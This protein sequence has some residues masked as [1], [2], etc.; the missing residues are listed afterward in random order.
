MQIR[1]TVKTQAP[2]GAAFDYLSDFTSTNDWD[3]GTVKTTLRHGDGGVGTTY[4]NRSTFL[5]RETH[6]TYVVEEYD[7][8]RHRIALRGENATVI[9]EDRLTLTALPD[10]G[11][12]LDY[13]ATFTFKGWVRFISVALR[14]ALL[15][16]GNEAEKGL[17]RSLDGLV[18]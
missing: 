8:D 16:L 12:E 13:R 5:G 15:R 4:D 7:A 18:G 3:P 14:P 9:A 17:K 11:S 10:G 2:I 1:R 6:L